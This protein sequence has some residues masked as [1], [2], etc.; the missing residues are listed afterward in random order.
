MSIFKIGDMLVWYPPDD[1]GPLWE[2]GIYK[3]INVKF[4]DYVLLGTEQRIGHSH[5]KLLIHRNCKLA[6][7][8]EILLYG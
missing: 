7:E 2:I 8:L 4:D 5:S 6:T 1:P 3:I